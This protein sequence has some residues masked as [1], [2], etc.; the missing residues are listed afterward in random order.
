MRSD[1]GISK[2]SNARV[3]AL[4]IQLAWLW[5]RW[6]PDSELTRWFTQ[7]TQGSGRNKR[8][9]RIAIV[10]I[11]R[12]LMISLWRYLEHGVVPAGARCKASVN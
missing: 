1:Q 8:A 11:A 9:R 3:R 12:R 5:L 7:R 2:Q 4:A 6:Q 10:A